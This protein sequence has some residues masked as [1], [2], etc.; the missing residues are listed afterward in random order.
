VTLATLGLRFVV[1]AVVVIV[2]GTVLARSGDV[3]AART[4]LGGV[5]VGSVFLALATSLPEIVTD[6]AAVRLGAI[7]LAVGD[8]FGSSMANMLILS[9]VSLVPG[10]ADVFRRTT[11][12]HVLYACLAIILTM[13]AAGTILIRSTAS[14]AGMGAGSL[15]ILVVYAVASRAAF[16]H[17]RVAQEAGVTI[18]M[19]SAPGGA[20]VPSATHADGNTPTLQRAGL[21]FLAAAAV[22]VMAA[23]QFAHA[24]EGIATL[25]G[26]GSTF[27]GTW[28]VGLSTSLPELVTSLAAVRLRAY[29]LAV[30]NLFGSNALNMIIFAGLDLAH[31]AAPVLSVADPAHVLTAMVA[32]ILMAVAIGT[33]A[34]RSKRVERAVEPG[35]LLLVMG[36]VLGIGLVFW[37]STAGAATPR[38]ARDAAG[39][40][41]GIAPASAQALANAT[42]LVS[43]DGFRADYLDRPGAVRLRALAERGAR[44][45]RLVPSFPSKTFPNHHTLVTGLYPEHHGIVANTMRDP[46][47]A[48]TFTIGDTL[49]ARDP[50][51]WG[52]E[53]IWVT[54]E[55]QGVRA[56]SL[57]W[58][59]GDYAIG[60][61][62][63]TYYLPYDG[64]MPN[65]ARVTQVLDWLAMPPAQAPRFVA[66]YFSTTDDAGHA[67]GPPSAQVD[68]AITH[69][70]SLVGALVDGLAARGLGDRVNLVIVSDHGMTDVSAERRIYL[71][72]Y[73]D[74]TDVEVVDWM[75]VSAVTPKPGKLAAV[76]DAL[77]H[78]HP[79][80]QVFHRDSV[81]ARFHYRD[82]VR[83]TPLVLLAGEGWTITS[84]ERAKRLPAPRGGTHGYDNA[85]PSMGALFI[86]AGPDIDEGRVLRPVA[87]VHV[88]PLLAR[89]L[90]VVPAPNDGSADSLAIV[91]R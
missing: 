14:V 48:A 89:L 27:V 81:P 8:L 39:G 9:L 90:G 58:P 16:R 57:F 10:G 66:L 22:I 18:E 13:M 56:A 75:P 2:A 32:V 77:R 35:S 20:A 62:R 69:V 45:E 41:S 72:D 55:K 23:P 30:G 80:L 29:D 68:T 78:A 85:L 83:I 54:A 47:I 86:A 4:R 40:V 60:G 1:A 73:I 24:A 49:V 17:S 19:S 44:A 67:Y 51:W 88:Y 79:Q 7:D 6:L 91:R 42:L 84:R 31:P 46:N 38:L 33:L 74:L 15:V 63:P 87:N 28:L 3:I 37:R 5:W 76:Y 52:G 61:R 64:R 59:G 25:T 43:L 70:D 50:R 36:Y 12:D 11:L 82:H 53:P 65:A 26:V 21:T 34:L 71:D